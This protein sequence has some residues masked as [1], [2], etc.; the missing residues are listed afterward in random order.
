MRN[1]IVIFVVAVVVLGLLFWWSGRKDKPASDQMS[2]SQMP[3]TVAPPADHTHGAP[4]G[5][6]KI[7]QATLAIQGAAG[8][9]LGVIT[10]KP[11]QL[12]AVEGT[13]YKVRFT[14]FYTFWNWDSGPIN[15][16]PE[17]KNPAVKVEV[18]KDGKVLYYTWAFQQM[19]FFR[20]HTASGET[21]GDPRLAF[22]LVAYDGLTWSKA[23]GAKGEKG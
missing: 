12:V 8:E 23:D 22:T 14:D 10:A 13:P 3:E 4:S 1:K 6:P 17:E 16:G 20:M 19:E 9:D 18:L 11:D 2:I 21:G 15:V 7:A 5:T